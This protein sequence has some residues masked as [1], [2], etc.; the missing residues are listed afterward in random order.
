MLDINKRLLSRKEVSD[1]Y[2]IGLRFLELAPS[3]KNGPAFVRVGRLVRYR[4]E[5]V[6]D[7]LIRNRHSVEIR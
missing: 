7:W 2:G 6:E 1:M 5:D 4:I 3:R